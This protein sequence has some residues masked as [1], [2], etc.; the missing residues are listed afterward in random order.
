MKP[1][2]T[3]LSR[4]L[5]FHLQRLVRGLRAYRR[6]IAK[7]DVKSQKLIVLVE[8]EWH[9]GKAAVHARDLGSPPSSRLGV[10]NSLGKSSSSDML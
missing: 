1:R 6:R 3:E 10:R 2:V 4:S 8:S 9:N 5:G 7:A